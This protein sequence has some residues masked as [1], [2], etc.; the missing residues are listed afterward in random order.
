M[1]AFMLKETIFHN[2]R[3]KVRVGY[4][5]YSHFLLLNFSTPLR[6]TLC[7][8]LPRKVKT[9]PCCLILMKHS[10]NSLTTCIQLR[11]NITSGTGEESQNQAQVKSRSNVTPVR[12]LSWITAVW[13]QTWWST[14]GGSNASVTSVGKLSCMMY[15]T[16][17]RHCFCDT[18]GK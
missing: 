11:G 17:E 9:R 2:C 12:T 7:W 18:C 13:K 16:G 10:H 1:G 4:L 3:S 14:E 15:H 6:N 8:L 5:G